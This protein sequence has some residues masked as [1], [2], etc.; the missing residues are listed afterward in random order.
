MANGPASVTVGKSS[1]I[2]YVQLW[3]YFES[4]GSSLKDSFV[5]MMTL[6]LGF[7][8]ALVVFATDKT[9]SWKVTESLVSNRPTLLITSLLGLL[10]MLFGVLVIVEFAKHINR[11][12]DRADRARERNGSLEDLL[13]IDKTKEQKKT[14]DFLQR[15]PGICLQVLIIVL[16]FTVVFLLGVILATS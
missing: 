14:K 4:R 8:G 1:D 5:H 6:I 13:E 7:A 11:N 16:G 2:D 9:L 12:F 3:E 10:L 15:T